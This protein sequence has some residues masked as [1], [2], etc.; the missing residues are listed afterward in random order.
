MIFLPYY[1]TV[2]PGLWLPV[3]PALGG[4]SASEQGCVAASVPN[5]LLPSPTSIS[6]NT[7]FFYRHHSITNISNKHVI[8]QPNLPHQWFS[9]FL[10]ARSH[11]V[12]LQ[13][14]VEEQEFCECRN[15]H[16]SSEMGDNH[17]VFLLCNLSQFLHYQLIIKPL[18]QQV[19]NSFSQQMSFRQPEVHLEIFNILLNYWKTPHMYV[20]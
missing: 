9:S 16:S 1:N 19:R 3:S 18:L 4:G 13:W 2:Q 15:Q 8:L 17:S 6:N 12:R 20:Q 14:F 7:I 10:W 11:F 5:H